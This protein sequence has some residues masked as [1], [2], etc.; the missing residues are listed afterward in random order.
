MEKY[1]ANLSPERRAERVKKLKEQGY[2]KGQISPRKGVTLSKE[3]RR[4]ISE[5]KK[6]QVPWHKG[7][8]GIHF[9]PNTEFKVG[10]IAPNTGIKFSEGW[11]KKLSE[12][13]I[14]TEPWNKGMGNKPLSQQIRSLA[15]YKRWVSETFERDN[16][17]CQEC[18]VRG[19]ELNA[20]HVIPF[21]V[22]YDEFNINTIEKAKKCDE[23][24]DIDNGITLC[25]KCHREI[26]HWELINGGTVAWVS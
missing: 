7:M 4:K 5:S 3:I 10:M 1:W 22:I 2:K 20:H 19:G 26:G 13:H 21:S 9:S 18:S 11:R 15:E 14:G 24:W 8:K 25:E 6:G 23:L 12:A 16:Y 17:T